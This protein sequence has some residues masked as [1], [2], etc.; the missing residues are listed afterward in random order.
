DRAMLASRLLA[1]VLADRLGAASV[2][3]GAP[4][5]AIS[6]GWEEEL[7]AARPDLLRLSGHLDEVFREGAVPMTALSRC[8]V[9]LATLPVVAR[10]RPD[11]VVVW[12]DAHADLHTPRTTTTGYL[13]GLA[14]AG[15]LGLWDSGLGAGLR[16]SQA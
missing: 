7:D 3:I 6:G 16:T 4:S 13:G 10:H 5:P 12:F 2:V 14:F 9:A 1:E 15:P 11:A 8:A